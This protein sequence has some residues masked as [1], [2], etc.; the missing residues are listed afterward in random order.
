MTSQHVEQFN[1]KGFIIKHAIS[2]QLNAFLKNQMGSLLRTTALK[3]SFPPIA[4]L[5][6][7]FIYQTGMLT[8]GKKGFHSLEEESL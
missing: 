2:K 5:M 6:T 3:S 1:L 4:P 8:T 7:F